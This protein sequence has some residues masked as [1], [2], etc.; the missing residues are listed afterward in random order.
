MIGL[1]I[2]AIRGS[3]WEGIDALATLA[4][5]LARSSST[6]DGLVEEHRENLH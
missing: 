5:S 6:A 2:N 1:Q 3:S 4:R